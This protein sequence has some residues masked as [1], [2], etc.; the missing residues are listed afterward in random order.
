MESDAGS[1]CSCLVRHA[2][3]RSSREL[4][5][6]VELLSLVECRR[7][8]VCSDRECQDTVAR[9]EVE[10]EL[11]LHRA[12]GL[13]AL[14]TA[15]EHEESV[16]S[17]IGPATDESG[18]VSTQHLSPVPVCNAAVRDVPI[19]ITRESDASSKS[20]Q[21][22]MKAMIAASRC[23]GS[24]TRQ[25]EG[26]RLATRAPVHSWSLSKARIIAFLQLCHSRLV[27]RGFRHPASEAFIPRRGRQV[28]DRVHRRQAGGFV[29]CDANAGVDPRRSRD[30][31][32]LPPPHSVAQR[33]RRSS[34]WRQLAWFCR[35]DDSRHEQLL[36]P[37]QCVPVRPAHVQ[38]HAGC[39]ERLGQR[40]RA[41]PLVRRPRSRSL[42]RNHA[43]EQRINVKGLALLAGAGH[44]PHQALSP[45]LNDSLWKMLRSGVPMIESTSKWLVRQ[46]YIKS[47]KFPDSKL[48]TTSRLASCV[49]PRPTSQK[50]RSL[51]SFLAWAK[52]DALIEEEIFLDVSA[53]L[54]WLRERGHNVQKTKAAFLADELT[55]WMNN[56]VQGR[57]LSE[58][59]S[60]NVEPWHFMTLSSPTLR[61]RI[62]SGSDNAS[63]LAKP[64]RARG[65]M[66]STASSAS[67]GG[68]SSSS[69]LRVSKEVENIGA[70]VPMSKKRV[71]WRFVLAGSEQVHTVMLE[72]SRIS[73][74]KRLKLDGPVTNTRPT[75]TMN[76]TW[77]GHAHT[78]PRR[79]K[80]RQVVRSGP[81]KARD[82]LRSPGRRCPLGPAV[83]KI[84]ASGSSPPYGSVWSSDMYVRR[85]EDTR[86]EL[87]SDGDERPPGTLLTWTFAFGVN[88]SIHKLELRDLEK[89]EFVV[90]LDCRELKRVSFDDIHADMWEF[91][92]DLED[93]HELDLVVTL[94]DE[95]R[96]T[97]SSLTAAPGLILA[98]PTLCSS[99]GGILCTRALVVPST[100]VTNRQETPNGRSLLSTERIR[101][102]TVRSRS[103]SGSQGL[104]D[105]IHGMH[106]V[107]VKESIQEEPESEHEHA[108]QLVPM[109]QPLQP[110]QEVSESQEGQE[111]QEANLIDFSDVAVHSSPQKPQ[112]VGMKGLIRSTLLHTRGSSKRSRIPSRHSH[113]W[114]Y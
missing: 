93:Q 26:A 39:A 44:R 35:L 23:V 72:H 33:P 7:T 43:D 81:R 5:G 96:R 60:T 58:V 114:I 83:G 36:R 6:L 75:G 45:R 48:P 55:E 90:V 77:E 49:A 64:R 89:G 9:E 95:E 11:V 84:S 12:Y 70:R 97:T 54:D 110:V 25:R 100:T 80:R 4:H 106:A 79:Y 71:T 16:A 104:D 46:L 17:A 20:D 108:P 40:V 111:V 98:R 34:G 61:T 99:L 8:R 56:V 59:Y 76:F 82:G 88:G 57:E 78:F 65:S 24:V 32:R 27:S 101:E 74:K 2:P 38:G 62:R 13:R 41:G 105:L 69:V 68:S 1:R 51:P 10:E 63:Y 73:A 30:V 29:R 47:F 103:F 42:H 22:N 67:G 19:R 107:S 87:L 37:H 102:L 28:Q 66:D 94:V 91:E 3:T 109:K 15:T 85:V 21:E 86:G 31:Q 18:V 14:Q 113:P 52:D 92:Y 112:R 50:N 53:D